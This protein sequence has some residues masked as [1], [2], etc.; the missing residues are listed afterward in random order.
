MCDSTYLNKSFNSLQTGKRIWTS[1]NR[2]KTRYI[3]KR[4][5]FPSNGKAYLNCPQF[6]SSQAV[7]PERQNQ[8]RAAQGFFCFKIYPKNPANPRVHWPKRDF[9]VKTAWNSDTICVLGQF[10]RHPHPITESRLLRS[11]LCLKY[12]L[13][14]HKCQFFFGISRFG[15]ERSC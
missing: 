1:L 10:K 13:N 8:T 15:L 7:A 9:F 5:Q 4:F 6:A 12:T 2:T 3:E 14:T 11:Y